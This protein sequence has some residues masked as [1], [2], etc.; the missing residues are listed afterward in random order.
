[1]HCSWIQ[2]PHSQIWFGQ[3]TPKGEFFFLQH[4][5]CSIISDAYIWFWSSSLVSVF[6]ISFSLPSIL[7]VQRSLAAPVLSK[8]DDEVQPKVAQAAP[9]L[10]RVLARVLNAVDSK[11]NEAETGHPC[12]DLDNTKDIKPA[13]KT[14]RLCGWV[15]SMG[16][17]GGQGLDTK[18]EYLKSFSLKFWITCHKSLIQFNHMR[19]GTALYFL[20]T[21]LSCQSTAVQVSTVKLINSVFAA[22]GA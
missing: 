14:Q 21:R 3:C 1:M 6:L 13:G 17:N 4:F 7:Q 11:E 22:T 8:T 12:T 20:S 2:A 5:I 15:S 9:G 19:E 18:K 10:S 16:K